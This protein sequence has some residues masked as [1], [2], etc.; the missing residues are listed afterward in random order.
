MVSSRLLPLSFCLPPL[1]KS[2]DRAGHPD[3][4]V[5]SFFGGVLPEIEQLI[6]QPGLP[7]TANEVEEFV[8]QNEDRAGWK[9]LPDDVSC[10]CD[11]IGIVFREG[12]ERTFTSELPCQPSR[13]V[14][15]E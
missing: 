8:H 3:R 11:A 12:G 7:S 4:F 10:R 9:H 1:L 15:G 13:W 6:S 2:L 14:F 5:H